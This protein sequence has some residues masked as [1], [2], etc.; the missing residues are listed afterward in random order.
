MTTRT[1]LS[2]D[3]SAPV[4][5]GQSGSLIALLHACLVTGYGT[6]IAPLWTRPYLDVTSNTAV[7]IP[8][9]GLRHSIQVADGGPGAGSF[10]EAR[11]RGYIAMS[12]FNTGT[13]PFPTITQ[14]A[15]GHFIRKSASL[16]TTP[17]PWR[18]YADEKGFHLFIAAGDVA[19]YWY[20]YSFGQFLSWKTNDLFCSYISARQT[21]NSAT[22]G[23]T[24]SPNTYIAGSGTLNTAYYSPRSYSAAGSA[25]PISQAI[26]PTLSNNFSVKSLGSA[27]QGY[28]YPIDGGLLMSPIYAIEANLI[29]G[30]VR[31]LYDPAHIKP[32]L[33]LDTFSATLGGITRSFVAQSLDTTAMVFIETSDTWDIP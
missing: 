15:N 10:R 6:R 11:V 21:E 32:I 2:T 20:P 30:T 3:A 16:D 25:V 12:A 24:I 19:A 31:G 1:F 5:T 33:D 29:R 23:Q 28:P 14:A 18:L 22:Y 27:G 26:N 7:F 8:Q 9:G 4:L 13:E 17:R